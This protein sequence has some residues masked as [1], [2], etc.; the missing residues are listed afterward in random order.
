M[1]T[2]GDGTAAAAEVVWTSVADP[3]LLELSSGDEGGGPFG[4][5]GMAFG[6]FGAL[7]IDGDGVVP[8]IG[9]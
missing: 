1:G 3:D 9:E 7:A 5:G 2:T 6:S 4:G 8:F